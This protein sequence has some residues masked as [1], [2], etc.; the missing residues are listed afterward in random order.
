MY[1][2][3]I[4]YCPYCM[5]LNQ[6]PFSNEQMRSFNDFENFQDFEDFEDIENFDESQDYDFLEEEDYSND[7]RA[8]RQEVN[9]ILRLLDTQKPYL[10]R[11]LPKNIME[12]F[13]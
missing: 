6:C 1:N 2:N 13:F 5:S 11:N 7:N 9:R 12:I 10:R 4:F 8:P 3:N